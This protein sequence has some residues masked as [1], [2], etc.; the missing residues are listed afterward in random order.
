VIP[1]RAAVAAYLRKLEQGIHR[2]G[3]D[4]PP[5]CAELHWHTSVMQVESIPLPDGNPGEYLSS[6]ARLFSSDQPEV[7]AGVAGIA[8]PAFFGMVLV[9]EAWG[10]DELTPEQNQARRKPLADTVGSYESRIV[11]AVDIRGNIYCLNRRRGEKPEDWSRYPITGRVIRSLHAI[12]LA[13]AERLP[14]GLAD[15][16]ALRRADAIPSPEELR[17]RWKAHQPAA[18]DQGN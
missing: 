10:N 8:Q 12:T 2:Y 18:T 7:K 6:V 5:M 1:D 3:W 17:A 13:V 14:P 9:N 15:L 11:S 16:E 4:Q